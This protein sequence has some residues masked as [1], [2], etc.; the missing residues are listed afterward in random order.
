MDVYLADLR[1]LAELFGGLPDRALCFAFVNGLPDAARQVIRAPRRWTFPA[2]SRERRTVLSD[3]R[4]ATVAAAMAAPPRGGGG[5]RAGTQDAETAR[6]RRAFQDGRA[7]AGAGRAASWA[8]WRPAA[9]RETARGAVRQRQRRFPRNKRSAA[10][11]QVT[12]EWRTLRRAGRH[13][14]HAQPRI[15]GHL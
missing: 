5:S 10:H 1:R 7:R 9:H 12:A 3:D 8:T 14:M 4:V 11:R 13:G 15:C 2:W 6:W